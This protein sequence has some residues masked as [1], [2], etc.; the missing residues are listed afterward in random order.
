[1]P[2]AFYTSNLFT[3]AMYL[4]LQLT[5]GEMDT[6]MNW[7]PGVHKLYGVNLPRTVEYALSV[8]LKYLFPVQRKPEVAYSMFTELARKASL[9]TF[10]WQ[11]GGEASNVDPPEGPHR[12]W[13]LTLPFPKTG[14]SPEIDDTWFHEGLEAGREFLSRSLYSGQTVP[15]PKGREDVLHKIILP[16]KKLQ[17]YLT[18]ARLLSFISDK[19][20]GIVIVTRN[21][22]ETEIQK[23]LNLPVFRR[24][25][26]NFE[27][28]HQDT[29]H[30][31]DTLRREQ[32]RPHS[33]VLHFLRGKKMYAFWS[34]CWTMKDLPKFHGIPKIHKNPWKLRPIV[35]MHS[36]VTSRLAIIL[37]SMLLP[38][39]RSIP[40][41]CESSRTLASEVAKFNKSLYTSTRLHTGDVS[42]MYTSIT[43][44]SF[45]I[46][47]RGILEL[48]GR[49]GRDIVDWVVC[50]SEFLWTHTIFQFGNTLLEQVDGIPM[51]I[52]C[53]PVFANLFMAFYEKFH[54]DRLPGN[55]FYRRYIDD[56]F[57]IFPSD[58]VVESMSYP[59][60]TMVWE[61]SGLGLS[62]LDVFFHTHPGTPEICFRPYEK[63]LNH[64]QYLPWASSHPVSVKK[65]L[66]KGEL[67]RIRAIC[68][69]QP[70]F[71]AWKAT[72]LSRLRL[73][74]WP[75]QVLKSWGRQVQW[76]NFFPSAGSD[77]KI[78]GSSILAV[79]EYNP[80][81]RELSS[82]DLWRTMRTVW[83]LG[84]PENQPYPS[85]LLIAKKRT[86]SLW[87]LVRSVN[88]NLLL[89]DSEE[90]HHEE[91]SD[92]LSDLDVSMPYSPL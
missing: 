59:G 21:W 83:S 89:Q 58:E 82:T 7:K 17:E 44:D 61:H 26:G 62:F 9:A 76:R 46:A 19:N 28:F 57:V 24:F 42:A 2:P 45:R 72:F 52:H 63:A 92:A 80:V 51:G 23:F 29:C 15:L 73:R 48:D 84:G 49:Y 11:Q 74:G 38:V 53:A 91:L 13:Q 12:S 4:W 18:A 81:W 8:N 47:I 25:S 27:D 16:P 41:I 3:Q 39:Q 40:W 60:L 69:R 54:L 14:F 78:K 31:L 85:Q 43:W 87:D 37:H 88:R 67:S 55:L 71:T 30:G 22:Y 64:H 50:A 77:A 6:L 75:V 65:G 33:E 20:L 5:Q 86:R 66:V 56:C 35:P 68:Y 10:F 36:Y 90:V 79:S 1:M 32:Q 34:Q 70:Y